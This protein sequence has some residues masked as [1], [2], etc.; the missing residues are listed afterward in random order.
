MKT[1]PFAAVLALLATLVLGTVLAPPALA[2]D[3]LK[4]S[5]P[6]KGAKVES[7]R[8]VKLTFTATVRFPK[9]VVRTGDAAY[10]DGKAAV[11]GPAVTQ[12]VKDDL[13][14]G[15]Y[16][17]AYRVV[18]SDGHPIEG[19]IPFTL[20]GTPEPSATPEA[21]ATDAG[22]ASASAAPPPPATAS[23]PPSSPPAAEL[24]SDEEDSGGIPGWAWLVVG[25]LTGVGIGLFLS[26]RNKKQP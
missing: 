17:I 1:S 21:S 25:G 26:M 4:S 23:A 2:H 15:E 3:T 24:A 14:P 13:P 22:S 18:S 12:K 7:L 8:E 10:Q 9:V 16:V 19:E 5:N 11:D 6:A 20:E